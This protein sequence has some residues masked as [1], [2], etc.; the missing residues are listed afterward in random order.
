MKF[1]ALGHATVV[2]SMEI[3]ADNAEEA[4]M[5][6]N[7]KFGSLINYCGM[8]GDDKLLGVPTSENARNVYPDSDV[9]FDDAMPISE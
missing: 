1:T 8:G 6:A 2:C 7:K 3:E 9:V 5:K 4:I